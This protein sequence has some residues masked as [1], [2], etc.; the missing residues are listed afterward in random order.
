LPPEVA[1]ERQ[2]DRINL[3]NST[4]ADH[5]AS[6]PTLVRWIVLILV[7]FASVSAYLTR[8]GISAANTTIQRDLQFDDQQM[9]Q[10][11][12]AFFLGYLIFQIPA[13]WFGNMVGTR[14]AFA[15]LA[16]M[17]SLCNLWS[18]I[19]SAMAV[20]WIARFSV[21]MFQAGLVPV[22]AKVVADWMPIRTRGFS[23][24]LIT[25]SMS[26]GAAFAM[27]LTGLMLTQQYSWRTIY[28]VYSA[29]GI[30]WAVGFAVYFRTLPQ[31][32]SG[33]NAAELR[34]IQET[35]DAGIVPPSPKSES[36]EAATTS[37]T[38]RPTMNDGS[39]AEAPRSMLRR[40]LVSVSLWG[41]C[42]QS[43][44]RAAGYAFFVT[45]FFAFLVYAYG[46]GKAEAG[47]L[48]SLHL[49]AVV[50]GSLTGGLLIDALLRITG[51]R[52]ISRSGTAAVVLAISGLLTAASA[53]TT[54]AS[55]LSVVIAAAALFSG[56]GGP[57][58]WAA[59]I[60]IGGR[61]TAIVMGVM[62]MAGGLAGVV[63]PT[64]L[65][66]WF[67]TIRE[68]GGDWNLVIYLHAAFYFLG[69]VCWLA[70]DPNREV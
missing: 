12:S 15:L 23:S 38:D 3:L 7:A 51:S 47:F 63:L 5:S 14:L 57:A 21:G 67:T 64:V 55:Q 25:A 65:G 49:I 8:Y 10:L 61:H 54:S 29:V 39:S 26:I 44:F 31:D 66:G 4:D 43:F 59:T 2:P 13:G 70:V 32:H 19:G 18:A 52:W 68:T 28:A 22:S 62:N 69:A 11:M 27:W 37:E 42:G 9:G 50:V 17:W 34:L 40:M 30:L 33:V 60:D 16:V 53:W 6:S 36:E 24:A 48:N 35:A 58:A 41:I 1:E 46:I 56:L 45:W 20:L